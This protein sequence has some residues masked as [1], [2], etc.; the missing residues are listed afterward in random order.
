[1]GLV[2]GDIDGLGCQVVD[3]GHNL[4]E[5][6]VPEAMAASRIGLPG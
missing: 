6:K 2:E 5:K 1:M 4:P 3:A